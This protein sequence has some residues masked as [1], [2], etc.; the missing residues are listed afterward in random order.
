[1]KKLLLVL[2]GIIIGA[3]AMFL[4][5]NHIVKDEAQA[6]SYYYSLCASTGESDIAPL[7]NSLPIS[8]STSTDTTLPEAYRASQKAYSA[9]QT[10]Y[11]G[12]VEV[13]SALKQ[14]IQAED[15]QILALKTQIASSSNNIVTLNTQCSNTASAVSL[16]S[17]QLAAQYT[18]NNPK[19]VCVAQPNETTTQAAN[20]CNAA[21]TTWNT[22]KNAWVNQQLAN[23]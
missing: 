17:N 18:I 13:N 5:V 2:A 4:Y 11:K 15:G 14:Q 8:D 21:Y 19:P 22:A 12:E 7:E 23:Q 10:L 20:R 6:T 1:M 3:S 16:N 9:L